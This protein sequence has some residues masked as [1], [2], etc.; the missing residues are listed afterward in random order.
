MTLGR[1]AFP[2]VIAAPSGAG[3]TTLAR[4]LVE[5]H[6]DI[7]FSVSV[8][9]RPPRPRERHGRDY[10]FVDDATFDRMIASDELAEWAAV[11]GHRY[12]TLRSEVT[13]ALDRGRVVVLDIDVQGARQ[14][15]RVFPDAVLVFVVPPTPAELVRRLASRASEDERERRLRL[16][17]ARRELA[18]MPEFDYLVVND[19]FEQALGR[20]EDVVRGEQARVARASGIAAFVDEFDRGLLDLLKGAGG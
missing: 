18:A 6:Q 16:E 8:T 4:G 12:G 10:H 14:V 1:G 11:H 17:T 2:F 3:K 20:M 9:T 15:R 7:V 5:R 19:E 13:A